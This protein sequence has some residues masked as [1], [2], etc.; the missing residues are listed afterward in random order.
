MDI[1]KLINVSK[2]FKDIQ[3]RKF[4]AAKNINLEIEEGGFFSLLGSSGSGKTTLLRMIAGFETPTEGEIY[5]NKELM[6]NIPPYKRPVN[7]VFQN[8]ALF[9]HLTVVENISFGLKTE[10]LTQKEIKKRVDEI[11]AIVKLQGFEN[12]YPRQLSGGQQQ[13]VALARAI[14][15]KPQV[16]LFDEPLAAL[17]LK[18][19]KQMQ[20]ELKHMQQKLGITFIYVTHDQQEALTMSDRIAVMHEG[21]VMQI[22]TP[23]DIYENPNSSFIADFIGETNLF[24]G[25]V[26]KQEKKQVTISVDNNL[27]FLVYY[28]EKL[29]IGQEVTVII[30]PEKA[31][32][33][34]LESDIENYYLGTIEEIVYNGTHSR[35]ITTLNKNQFLII[36]QQNI[37]TD[38]LQQCPPHKQVKIKIIPENIRIITDDY[39]PIIINNNLLS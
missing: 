20:L 10:K 12:R 19:R 7:T 22:G 39:Y 9:P 23:L 28:P 38:Y 24:K 32:I 36:S 13:R 16:L 25:Q 35:I 26:I 1:L 14:V 2:S 18:L 4:F 30:R 31:I 34:P 6:N 29:N 33:Y 37:S 11:L 17:D 21:E 5:I 27:S 8:Y 3:N 15:K